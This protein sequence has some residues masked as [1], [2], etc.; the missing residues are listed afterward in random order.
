MVRRCSPLVPATCLTY[1]GE[2]LYTQHSPFALAWRRT[3]R[4]SLLN[5]NWYLSF[6]WLRIG[7]AVDFETREVTS[8]TL[9]L[10]S[11]FARWEK[12]EGSW[13]QLGD[14]SIP[15]IIVERKPKAS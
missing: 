9:C 1:V 13:L 3:M 8:I 11:P 5:L 7:Y 2:A 10:T 15:L 6:L 12:Y 14:K 4:T